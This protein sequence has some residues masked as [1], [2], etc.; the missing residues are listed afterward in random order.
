MKRR[1]RRGIIIFRM[2]RENNKIEEG[3]EDGLKKN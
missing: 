2:K 3:K 1:R